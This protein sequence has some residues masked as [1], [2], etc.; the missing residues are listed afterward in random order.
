MTMTVMMM[1]MKYSAIC[2]E[3]EAPEANEQKEQMDEENTD[4]HN[5]NQSY[6]KKRM[7]PEV[8]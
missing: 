7:K 5:G 2:N 6:S 3:E 4:P 1:M 8:G